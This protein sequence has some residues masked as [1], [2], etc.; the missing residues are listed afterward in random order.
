MP[1]AKRILFVCLGNIVRSPLAENL[2]AH[3]AGQAEVGESYEVDSA[4]TSGYHVGERP[5]R[6]MRQVAA[7]HGL[8]Y[9]GRARQVRQGDLDDFDLVVAMDSSNR[10]QLLSMA[11][12]PEQ[13]EKIRLM[14]EFDPKGGP[15]AGVPDPYY[16][17]ID[18]FEETYGIVARA[19]QG[20]LEAIESGELDV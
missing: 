20:L 5:D 17:G 14:R 15:N 10:S 9:D 7:K 19:C 3:L 13:Q 1:E 8:R 12:T 4:G 16:G 18:G 2:F 6:R 11:R